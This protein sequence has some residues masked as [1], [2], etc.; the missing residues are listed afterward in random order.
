MNEISLHYVQ[1]YKP[2][3]SSPAIKL[4]LRVIIHYLSKNNYV[5]VYVDQLL[6]L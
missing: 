3:V 6:V 1:L 2:S 5:C 4:Q